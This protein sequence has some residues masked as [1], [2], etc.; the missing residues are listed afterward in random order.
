M[1]D[2]G[3]NN[4]LA[5]DSD[6]SL[7]WL[8]SDEYDPDEGAVDTSR[9]VMFAGVLLLLLVA[10]IGGVWWYSNYLH[11]EQV[12]A[13]GS[14]IKAPEGP[15]KERPADPGGKEFAGTGNVAPGV[16]EGVSA[17]TQLADVET[18][19]PI[20]APTTAPRPT[21]TAHSGGGSAAADSGVA[22]QVGA[23]GSRAKAESG[24]ATLRGQT[25]LLNGV[26]YRIVQGQA[27]IGTVYR[28][29]ALPGD[30]A[31]ARKLCNGLKADGIACNI[32]Q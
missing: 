16:G 1:S 13:D 7:P 21:I 22:V 8:E 12:V 30:L 26:R 28:L 19:T 32:K 4:E 9:I 2:T 18:S 11:G 29:Q 5:L 20:A 3:S 15:Y 25:T 24:W 31:T 10:G 27:D 23:Y 17:E 14:T 6:D